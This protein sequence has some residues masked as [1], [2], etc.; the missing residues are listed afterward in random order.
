MAT[1]KNQHF[2]PRCY[3]RPFTVNGANAAI[4]LY[5]IDQRRFIPFAPVKNQCSGDY[6]YGDDIGLEK[7]IQTLEGAYAAALREITR[8]GYVLTGAHA[9]TLRLF[10][11]FQHLRTESAARRSVEM[12][13]SMREVIG[14]TDS[15]FRLAIKDAVIMA[16]HTF[17]DAMHIIDD[18]TIC[19]IRNKTQIPFFTSDNPA[20]LT[21]KWSITDSRS[22][23]L[24]FGFHSAGAIV[25]LPLTPKL[26]CLGY[27]GDVYSVPQNRGIA[28]VRSESDIASF[29]QH[30]ILNCRANLFVQ[31]AE[32]SAV[33]HDAFSE[34]ARNRPTNPYITTQAVLAI[35]CCRPWGT[36][37]IHRSNC[38]H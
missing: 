13:T 31:D 10:W 38:A 9:T 29:N 3:L 25:L 21:N 34:V 1:N 32:H 23:G 15:S 24:S 16:M 11:V 18:L 6:F 37:E 19:L 4:N 26:L 27:D 5:N 22:R 12:V 30:Q 14:L 33:V 7:A 36:P 8:P 35:S 17:T 20:V 2:V 28:D